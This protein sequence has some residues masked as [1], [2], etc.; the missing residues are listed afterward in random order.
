MKTK[1]KWI[2]ILLYIFTPEDSGPCLVTAGNADNNKML[3]YA[4][5]GKSLIW[6]FL[7]I[8]SGLLLGQL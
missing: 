8:V 4:D 1:Y 3:F 5:K 2:V 6:I 7:S